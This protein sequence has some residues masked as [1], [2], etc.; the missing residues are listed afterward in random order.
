M[1]EGLAEGRKEIARNLKK[2]GIPIALIMQST[3]LSEKEI[4]EL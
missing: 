2:A 4:Q 3:N 1:A